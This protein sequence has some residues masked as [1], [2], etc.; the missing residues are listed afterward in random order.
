MLLVLL[1]LFLLLLSREVQEL[2]DET[3]RVG[4]V[5]YETVRDIS[6]A[7]KAIDGLIQ[8]EENLKETIVKTEREN[9]AIENIRYNYYCCCYYYYYC[10]CY[11]Y[12][13]C[14]CY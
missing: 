11:Y 7:E 5:I 9:I 4:F 1:L 10:C 6:E 3:T 13:Y 12:C 8:L 14:C 2:Q